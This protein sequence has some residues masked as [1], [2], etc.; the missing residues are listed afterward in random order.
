VEEADTGKRRQHEMKGNVPVLL[1]E[2]TRNEAGRAMSSRRVVIVPM[3]RGN[4]NQGTLTYMRREGLHL[5]K[6]L[7]GGNTYSVLR[8]RGYSDTRTT[9]KRNISR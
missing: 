6:E 5:E 4:R 8:D 7:L 9:C 1:N 2:G 3:K